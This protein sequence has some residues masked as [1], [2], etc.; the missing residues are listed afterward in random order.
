MLNRTFFGFV[1]QK[2]ANKKQKRGIFMFKVVKEVNGTK[3]DTAITVFY[4]E[5]EDIAKKWG[6]GKNT[7]AVVY[8]KV[9]NEW[10]FERAWGSE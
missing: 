7:E 5:A 9:Y 6:K 1:W 2:K 4:K 3:V 8:R 10:I